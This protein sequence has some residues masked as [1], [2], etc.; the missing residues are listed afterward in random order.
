MNP[1]REQTDREPECECEVNLHAVTRGA[2]YL[3]S[4]DPSEVVAVRRFNCE[5]SYTCELP[6]ERYRMVWLRGNSTRFIVDTDKLSLIRHLHS[7][8]IA[9]R[10]CDCEVCTNDTADDISH[11]EKEVRL[12]ESKPQRQ[13][14]KNG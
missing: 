14:P 5:A 1:Y 3:D 7:A 8:A 9:P 11:D 10:V 6:V 13:P 4:F 2:Y 12:S